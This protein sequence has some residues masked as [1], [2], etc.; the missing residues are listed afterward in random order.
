M[1]MSSLDRCE[2]MPD[3]LDDG[4]MFPAMILNDDLERRTNEI[5]DNEWQQGDA[6]ITYR[7]AMED[8][9]LENCLLNV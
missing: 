5:A 8:G 1:G 6:S 2:L 7:L 4:E 3:S 9:D